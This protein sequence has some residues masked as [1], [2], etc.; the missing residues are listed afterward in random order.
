MKTEKITESVVKLAAA[1]FLLIGGFLLLADFQTEA[2]VSAAEETLSDEPRDYSLLVTDNE[3]GE[4]VF[5]VS[6]GELIDDFN[7][8][9]GSDYLTAT[10]SDNWYRY[11][12][13]SP[14]FGYEAKRYQFSADKT[15]W[16]M[17]TL[18]FYAPER[19]EIYEIRMTFDDHGYQ[20]R[21]HTLFK[22]LCVC[23]EKTLLPE[24]SDTDAEELFESLY[25][26][27][28]DNFFGNHHAYG[29]SE[30]P[31]LTSV[32]S[33]GNIGLYCFYGAGNIEICF[34]PLTENAVKQLNLENIKII[35]Y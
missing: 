19:D 8:V 35:D 34:L 20:E 21:F 27:A 14:R 32:T 3:A 2:A 11:S 24:L 26:Q 25:A 4:S 23:M 18:S 16:P 15:V 6:L 28:Y 12:E 13:R 5:A 10:E 31:P 7:R 33:C 1:L 9:C 17:P 22:Q 29:D 30:R